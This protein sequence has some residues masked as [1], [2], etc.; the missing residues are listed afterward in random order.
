[1]GLDRE[2]LANLTSAIGLVPQ[3][4]A[5]W[6]NRGLAYL[7]TG[8]ETMLGNARSDLERAGRMAPGH[9]DIE[10]MLALLAE[11]NGDL[12]AAAGHY[13]K[14]LQARPDNVRLL[15]VLSQLAEK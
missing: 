6:A 13:E 12:D 8:E 15:F 1:V 5:A 10:E 3:E 2:A 9:A 11:R 7:R 14:V 4:P